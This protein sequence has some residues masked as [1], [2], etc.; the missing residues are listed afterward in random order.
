MSKSSI[1]WTDYTWSPI[2]VRVKSDAAKIAKAKGYTSLVQIAEKMAGHVGPHCEHVSP[3]CEKCY[4]GTNNHRCLPSNGTGL[5][6]DRRSRDLVDVFL[7]E[8]ILMEPLHWKAPRRI[9]VENQSDLFGEW[10]PRV[11]IDRVVG[12]MAWCHQHTFQVLTKRAESLLV[13]SQAMMALKRR[14]RGVLMGR[15]TGFNLPDDTPGGMDWPLPNVWFGVSVENQPTADDRIGKL[16]R[17]PA[18]LRFISYEPALGPLSFRWAKWD[19]GSPHARRAKQLP[20]VVRDGKVL[21]GVRDH[22]DCLRMLDWIIVGGESGPGARSFDVQ[23]AR[24]T[25]AQCKAAGVA[26]FV[27]QLGAHVIQDGERRK[28]RDKKGGDWHEWPH[29]IRVREFPAVKE[30]QHA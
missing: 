7:D 28:K 2:R 23:W 11:L 22:L 20:N 14:E 12:V 6:F 18:A 21:A 3:G 13:Y 15:S 19:D 5:P 8:K 30:I 26:C 16:V 17:T 29:D 25:V 10:V 27:K 9:F 24:D 1:E 4:A